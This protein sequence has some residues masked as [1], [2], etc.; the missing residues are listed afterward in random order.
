MKRIPPI[1]VKSFLVVEP[2]NAIAPKVPAVTRNVFVMAA[3]EKAAKIHPNVSPLTVAKIMNYIV[4][5]VRDSLSMREERY[6]TIPNSTNAM[7]IIAPLP[8]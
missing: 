5:A 7:T 1:F 8:M 3:D 4:A 6:Q 2:I